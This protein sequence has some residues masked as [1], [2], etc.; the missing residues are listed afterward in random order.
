MAKSK[1]APR[2][3]SERV[4]NAIRDGKIVGIKAGV[5]PHRAIGVWAVVVE[6]RVFVRSWGLKPGGW[7]RT[8]VEDSR[9]TMY[10]GRRAMQIR[11]V[12]TR[13]KRLKDAVSKAYREK[14][15]TPGSIR[16][17]RDLSRQKCRETT[18][19]LVPWSPSLEPEARLPEP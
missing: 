14:Y 9:G 12:R 7:Y 18:T 1:D 3:F 5:Q 16:Y 6:G 19:E 4:V 13:S 8:F 10:V 15:N 2:R 11:A 17:V